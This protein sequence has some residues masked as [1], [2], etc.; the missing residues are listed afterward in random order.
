MRIAIVSLF[1]CFLLSCQSGTKENTT[2]GGKYLGSAE[3]TERHPE[4]ARLDLPRRP[5]LENKAVYSRSLPERY[6]ETIFYQGG[7]IRLDTLTNNA[8]FRRKLVNSKFRSLIESVSWS[9]AN[10]PGPIPDISDSA[11][12]MDRSVQYATFSIKGHSCAAIYRGV[13][14]RVQQYYE[15]SIFGVACGERNTPLDTY[16]NDVISYVQRI[17]VS[18]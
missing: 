4:D 12:S 15:S 13:G 2:V 9:K 14:R 18:R 5:E 7:V 6:Q 10:L 3:W 17:D 11:I 16:R 1:C 8:G